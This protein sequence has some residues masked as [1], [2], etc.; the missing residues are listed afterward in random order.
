MAESRAGSISTASP[1]RAL[2]SQGD[3]DGRNWVANRN[4]RWTSFSIIN[5]T[6]HDN[7]LFGLAA[8]TEMTI[9]SRWRLSA[10]T[11]VGPDEMKR[12]Q[13]RIRCIVFILTHRAD[14]LARPEHR[15]V[16]GRSDSARAQSTGPRHAGK[17][18]NNGWEDESSACA[19]IWLL[20][21]YFSQFRHN[22]DSKRKGK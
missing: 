4:K 2:W 12:S 7:P 15:S 5:G 17:S 1:A 14:Q 6:T 8:I 11:A 3:P 13:R 16:N 10:A 19:W 18:R 21:L 20:M 22:T 9:L